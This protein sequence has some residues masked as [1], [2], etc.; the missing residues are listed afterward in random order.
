MRALGL[1][2][3]ATA[4]FAQ[5]S[6]PKLGYVTQES[7]VRPVVGIPAVAGVGAALDLGRPFERIVA[8]PAQEYALG[9]VP[10]SGQ[11]MR[12]SLTSGASTAVDGASPRPR[13]IL[14][15][16]SGAT[17][18]LQFDN[19]IYQSVSASGVRT[20]DFG[21]IGSD[22]AAAAVSD[23]GGWITVA[24]GGSLWAIGPQGELRKVDTGFAATAIAFLAGRADL[25]IAGDGRIASISDLPG[26]AD[27]RTIP[28]GQRHTALGITPDNAKA[29]AVSD[30]GAVTLISLQSGDAASVDCGCKPVGVLHL[31]RGIFRL[32]NLADGAFKIFDSGTGEVWFAPESISTEGAA[33]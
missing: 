29:V 30:S 10:D 33:Q 20:V 19:A 9:V 22:I 17:A 7:S 15:S 6:G 32:T 25:T 31:G 18:L 4:A 11:V 5:I 3:F 26:R 23:D 21:F 27:V 12:V 28:T 13:N 2:L 14:F 16:T 1:M 24:S 8:A